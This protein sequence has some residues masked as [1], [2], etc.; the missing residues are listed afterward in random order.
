M[1]YKS[2]NNKLR[3]VPPKVRFFMPTFCPEPVDRGRAE[4]FIGS[5]KPLTFTTDKNGYTLKRQKR[6]YRELLNIPEVINTF[7]TGYKNLRSVSFQSEQKLWTIAT[8]VSEI[9]CFNMNGDSINT[10]TIETGNFPED[11]AVTS[12][13]SLC[14]VTWYVGLSIN[15]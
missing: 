10:I 2:R 3:K 6:P 7:N 13:G 1:E 12:E 9:K 15:L 14:I 5:I 4:K 8:E 11:I